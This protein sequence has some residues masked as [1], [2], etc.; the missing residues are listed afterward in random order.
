MG[1]YLK[2]GVSSS[3]HGGVGFL[4]YRNL[5]SNYFDFANS[6]ELGRLIEPW[7][8]DAMGGR[9]MDNEQ[10]SFSLSTMPTSTS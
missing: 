8:F 3:P 4:H 10:R 7:Q 1:R 9:P 6:S 5:M 2:A